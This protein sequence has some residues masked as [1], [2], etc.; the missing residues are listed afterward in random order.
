MR[1]LLKRTFSGVLAAAGVVALLCVAYGVTD[2]R[3]YEF[4]WLWRLIGARGTAF[5]AALVSGL[6]LFT[7]LALRGAFGF[8]WLPRV[9]RRIVT[10]ALLLWMFAI[11]WL[12][13]WVFLE[14]PLTVRLQESFLTESDE[15][16][17][18]DAALERF[19][20]DGSLD[21]LA[22]HYPDLDRRRVAVMLDRIAVN[23]PS[24]FD[25]VAI[26]EILVEHAVRYGV[27]P[28]LLLHWCYID[29]FYG[30]A[31][32]GPMPFFAEVNGEMFRDL[33]Q[34]HLP[35]WFIE[36]PIRVALIEGPW[37][38]YLLPRSLATKLRYAFQ[39]ATYDIA[40]APFMNSV[41]S[42]LFLILREY[43]DEFPELFGEPGRNDPLAR[44]FLA[45]RDEGL[46]EP[47]HEPYVHAPR[48]A[49]YYERYRKHLIDFGR[50]AV[51]RIS[52]DFRFATK[53]QALVARYYSDQYAAR[54]GAERWAQ[55]S[56]RQQT[57]LLA[58]LRD[59]YTP[60]IG[61]VS[62]NLYMVPEFNTTPIGFLAGEV[63]KNFDSVADPRRTWVPTDREKLWGATGLM[64][65]VLGEVWQTLSGE[66]LPGFPPTKT[67]DDAVKVLAR[68]R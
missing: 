20:R 27:S 37:F 12:A 25:D 62:Y 68:V 56:E 21:A 1:Q 22:A 4:E 10:G 11:V 17:A 60:S 34:A 66:A 19:S 40:I 31:P 24:V 52:G 58:M 29:S 26:G 65:R 49:E 46:L 59:V 48:T 42:D 54:I 50:A 7:A 55:L 30:E 61:R 3:S 8:A 5:A 63:S 41:M 15:A 18:V 47:Y 38:E 32:A 35:S 33:V 2:L 9:A 6:V 13:D 43:P 36:S 51:Y 45:L 39:K 64:L 67:I 23:R 16:A 44:A 53:A 57:A 14:K 28:A